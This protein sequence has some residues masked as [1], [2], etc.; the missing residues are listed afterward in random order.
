MRLIV[1]LLLPVFLTAVAP[2]GAQTLVLGETK[3]GACYRHALAQR[4]DHRALADCDEAL[5]DT[6][7]L[8]RDRAA[9]HVNRGIVLMHSG[10]EEAALAAFDEAEATGRIDPQTLALNRSSALIRLGRAGE[11]L[12]QTAIVIDAGQDKIA[13]AWFN[14][15]V[16]LEMLGDVSG[17]YEAFSQAASHRPDWPMVQRELARFTVVSGS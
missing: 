5:D 7:V 1:S 2:A 8:R 17:A 4:G 9:T 11:A 14:R 16:A 12:A 13:E 10:E 6:L 3:A 15:G